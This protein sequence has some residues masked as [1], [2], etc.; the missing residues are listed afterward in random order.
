MIAFISQTLFDHKLDSTVVLFCLLSDP[1]VSSKQR[2]YKVKDLRE[3]EFKPEQLVSDICH[4]YVYLGTNN[5]FC[6]AV[7]GEQR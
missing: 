7:L 1:K 4:I 2:D 5:H 3:H 6:K